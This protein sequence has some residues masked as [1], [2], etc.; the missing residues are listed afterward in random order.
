[1]GLLTIVNYAKN[2]FKTWLFLLLILVAAIYITCGGL[3]HYSGFVPSVF[4]IKIKEALHIECEQ[5]SLN[6][7]LVCP[8]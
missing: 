5:P 3:L 7:Q 8:N 2:Y 6:K 4:L 1:M